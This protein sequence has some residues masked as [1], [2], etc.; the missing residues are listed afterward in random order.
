M[1][2]CVCVCSFACLFVCVLFVVVVVVVGGVICDC[3][4]ARVPLM[5]SAMDVF[6][7]VVA[8][9]CVCCAFAWYKYVMCTMLSLV[10]S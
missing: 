5:L 9:I 10:F 2:L 7:F 4:R 3:T 1:N 8:Y 6:M